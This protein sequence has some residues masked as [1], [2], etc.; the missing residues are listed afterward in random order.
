[1]GNQ[2]LFYTGLIGTII[3][4]PLVIYLFIRLQIMEVIEDITGLRLRK[5][6]RVRIQQYRAYT[7]G[8]LSETS[9]SIKLRKNETTADNYV[10]LTEALEKADQF[11]E[12]TEDLQEQSKG[13][14]KNIPLQYVDISEVLNNQVI[15]TGDIQSINH[16]NMD[17]TVL[18][19]SDEETVPL[20]DEIE[21]TVLLETPIESSFVVEKD[22]VIVH[23]EPIKEEEITRG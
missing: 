10:S 4:F 3:T 21:E 20:T 22:I 5:K 23:S 19:S 2:I 16:H 1:M 6:S 9:K 11:L 8:K 17:E 12:D 18:L 7:D 13:K 15:D 14:A